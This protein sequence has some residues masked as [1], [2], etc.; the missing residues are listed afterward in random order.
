[1]IILSSTYI[2]SH[3]NDIFFY[4]LAELNKQFFMWIKY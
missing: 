2:K 3:K 1:M 4:H